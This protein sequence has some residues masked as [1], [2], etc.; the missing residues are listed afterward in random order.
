MATALRGLTPKYLG[1]VEVSEMYGISKYA[2]REGVKNGQI[3]HVVVG[4]KYMI[5][6]DA[7]QQKLDNGENI[8]E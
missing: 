8:L 5:D 3:K 1:I 6:V 2:L 7:L 4:H